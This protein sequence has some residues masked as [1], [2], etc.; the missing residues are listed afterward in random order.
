MSN[1]QN[2]KKEKF[3]Q[4]EKKSK[5]P[6][7]GGVIVLGIAIIAGSFFLGNKGSDGDQ[8]AVAT[9][10]QTFDYSGS[11]LP[12]VETPPVQAANGKV[13]VT[14]LSELKEKKFIYTQ[15]QVN[16]KTIPLTAIALPDGKAIVAVS[17]CEPCNSDSFR[18]EGTKL[19]C[20]ACNTTWALDSFKG[21]SGGCQAYP[22]DR[23][24][25]TQNGDNLEV[26][27]GILD[28]WKPRV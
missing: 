22:P 7:I 17:I 6:L 13:V 15:Y 21:L 4:P 5:A 9:L 19:V 25:Y 23:L 1:N 3:T 16:H 12:Q 14:T 28:A 8:Y 26:D 10:G 27:Q 20:N 24:I 18:I 11:P 2:S